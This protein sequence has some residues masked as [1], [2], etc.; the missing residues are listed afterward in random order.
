MFERE[1]ITSYSK[2]LKCTVWVDEG[3]QDDMA[4][5]EAGR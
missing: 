5:H 1:E 2:T 3:F 4:G